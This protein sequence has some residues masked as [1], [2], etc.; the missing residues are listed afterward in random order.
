MPFIV[1]KQ[2]TY[3]MFLNVY[4]KDVQNLQMSAAFVSSLCKIY[5]I[6]N[7]MIKALNMWLDETIYETDL[8]SSMQYYLVL[9]YW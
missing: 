2:Q 7:S 1:Q 6:K 3:S 8:G 5:R 4:N 9:N